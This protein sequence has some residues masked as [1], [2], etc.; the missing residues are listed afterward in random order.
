M[1]VTGTAVLI[2]AT[3]AGCAH[4]EIFRM[5]DAQL[6][7]P[8]RSALLALMTFVEP[9]SNTDLRERFGFP[10]GKKVRE[11]LKDEGLLTTTTAARNAII[12][13]LTETGWARCRE[14]LTTPLPGGADRGYRILF[15]VLSCLDQYLTVNGLTLADFLT[16][17]AKPDVDEAVHS[18]T[19]SW[20]QVT[21]DK[22]AS[23]PGAWVGLAA[24]REALPDVSRDDFDDALLQLDLLPHVSLIPEV[25]QKALAA[26]DRAAAIHVGGEDKHLLQIRPT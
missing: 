4:L 13:A 17:E 3:C 9:A 6:G 25:N 14:E 16:P 11:R 15:G 26:T 2:P 24:L 20:L 1:M 23:R 7:I 19:E 18:T 8:E 10:I 5:T 21:Y 12:H 22:L